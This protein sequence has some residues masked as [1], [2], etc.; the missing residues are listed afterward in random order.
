MP[1]RQVT[2]E[3][4]VF[5]TLFSLLSCGEENALSTTLS[6]QVNFGTTGTTDFFRETSTVS[7][8]PD[9]PFKITLPWVVHSIMLSQHITRP[10]NVTITADR[11]EFSKVTSNGTNVPVTPKISFL[12]TLRSEMRSVTSAT[13]LSTIPEPKIQTMATM[14]TDPPNVVL[15][16]LVELRPEPDR[17]IPEENPANSCNATDIGADNTEDTKLVPAEEIYGNRK[18]TNSVYIYVFPIV[19]GICLLTTSILTYF[20]I[21]RLRKANSQMNK[22]SCLLLIAV[23]LTDLLTMCFALAEICFLFNATKDNNGF[24]PLGKCR[25]MLILERLSAI[26]HAT[27][28]WFTVI[29]AIQRYVCVSKPFSASKHIRIRSSYILIISVSVL[30]IL[31]HICRVFDKTFVSVNV[32]FNNLTIVTCQGKHVGWI[33]NPVLY[34]CTFA[35][36][37]IVFTQFIPG[38]VMVIFV[39]LMIKSLRDTSKVTKRM[40]LSDSKLQSDRRQ[41]SLF[42]AIVAFVVFCVEVSSGIFLSLNAWEMSTGQEIVSYQSLKTATT[43]F[44]LVLYVSYFVIFL[45]YCL[46]SKDFR[47]ILLSVWCVKRC[48]TIQLN[49]SSDQVP[50]VSKKSTTLTLLPLQDLESADRSLVLIEKHNKAEQ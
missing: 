36:T 22:A 46:M 38:I 48:Q 18:D 37:R 10:T 16:G 5:T 27:S 8:F 43:A 6:A 24:I 26:P 19:L 17:V 15:G 9:F 42:V 40:K 35:W 20:L 12:E 49:C 21:Q 50:E 45:L 23:A 39:S 33:N 41:L 31:L 4:V 28:T 11:T 7:P 29:L 34:E 44:D 14:K 25:A 30:S 13:R 2:I 1:L 47:R 3:I 32:K